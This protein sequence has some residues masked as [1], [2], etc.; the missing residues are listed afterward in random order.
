MSLI[1]DV[2]LTTGSVYGLE[3]TTRRFFSLFPELRGP[4]WFVPEWAE[5]DG[6]NVTL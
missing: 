3:G 4:F 5:P 1:M 6:K 2:M